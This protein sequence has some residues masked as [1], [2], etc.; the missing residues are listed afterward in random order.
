MRHPSRGLRR[1]IA[2]KPG[3]TTCQAA[4]KG[5]YLATPLSLHHMTKKC[6]EPSF[7]LKTVKIASSN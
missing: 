1:K 6:I 7:L 3:P 2:V 5:F 4:W